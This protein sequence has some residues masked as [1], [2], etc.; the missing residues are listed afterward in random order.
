MSVNQGNDQIA[1]GSQDL[2]SISGAKA[3]AIFQKG[4]VTHV[5]RPIF[6]APMSP[7]Q[8]KQALGGGL[9]ARKGGDDVNHLNAGFAS[10]FGGD[11]AGELSHLGHARPIWL[12]IVRKR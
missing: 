3:R 9:L 2:W 4:D 10:L 6:N 7:N 1:Q 5:M 12:Q 11:R 8:F